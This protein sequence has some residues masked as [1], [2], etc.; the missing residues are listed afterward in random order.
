MASANLQYKTYQFFESKFE[1]SPSIKQKLSECRDKL[2]EYK[3]SCDSV[4]E[5]KLSV[6][7]SESRLPQVSKQIG[8]SVMI[9]NVFVPGSGTMFAAVKNKNGVLKVQF[10]LGLVELYS[11]LLIVG[12]VCSIVH[13]YRIYK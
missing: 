11:C 5:F 12:F 13:G 9:M 4:S 7:F 10:L 2:T 1:T 3:D 6:P 8:F